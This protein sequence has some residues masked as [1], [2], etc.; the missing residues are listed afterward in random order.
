MLSGV[1]A[2][3]TGIMFPPYLWVGFSFLDGFLTAEQL[4]KDVIV[5]KRRRPIFEILLFVVW[6][7]ISLWFQGDGTMP[8]NEL[9]QCD[10]VLYDC[11]KKDFKSYQSSL[12]MQKLVQWK[13]HTLRVFSWLN[14]SE[15]TACL[16][17]K[18]V[19]QNK[20]RALGDSFNRIFCSKI[21]STYFWSSF[22]HILQTPDSC[23]LLFFEE[24]T[25]LHAGTVLCQ[26]GTF[27]VATYRSFCDKCGKNRS[28]HVGFV[29][30]LLQNNGSPVVHARCFK[31]LRH[32]SSFILSWLL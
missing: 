12:T 32:I 18:L 19:Q 7:S 4:W 30:L 13:K 23:P 14:C 8:R 5:C 16:T 24:I 2:G 1:S 10:V 22:Y 20:R 11:D 9:E 31:N 21:G 15:W 26:C 25:N 3:P 17:A 29:P 27:C 6:C 28:L